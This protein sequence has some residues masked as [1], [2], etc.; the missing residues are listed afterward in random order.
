MS[1]NRLG[2]LNDGMSALTMGAPLTGLFEADGEASVVSYG[3][4]FLIF[5]M[6]VKF[7][8][9]DMD[10]FED[11]ERGGARSDAYFR[12]G[13]TLALASWVLFILAGLT[14]RQ[15]TV[16][17][18]WLFAALAVSTLWLYAE[19]RGPKTYPVQSLWSLS[20]AG[21][22]L[23]SLVL[24]RSP[25]LAA[26]TG[27]RVETVQWAAIMAMGLILAVEIIRADW[28]QSMKDKVLEPGTPG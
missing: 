3:L 5:A 27:L 15:P 25:A 26:L 23:M 20:N 24:V 6:R 17:A 4:A 11:P 7:W 9:D 12:I 28:L 10:F 22:V 21:Y 18:G 8:I 14:V 19:I 2:R 1:A 16:A 13:M